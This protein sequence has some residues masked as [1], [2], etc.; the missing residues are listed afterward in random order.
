MNNDLIILKFFIGL[1]GV[2][3][4]LF[5]FDLRHVFLDFIINMSGRKQLEV[6]WQVFFIIKS[7]GKVN[8]SDS[9]IGVDGDPQGLDIVRP[10]SPSGEVR[11][12]ELDLVPSFV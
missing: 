12:I 5:G 4:F 7:L 6:I 8:P 10:I 9:A 1:F 11:Q 3:V 2:F